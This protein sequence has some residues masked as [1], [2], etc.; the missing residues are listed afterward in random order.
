MKGSLRDILA[1]VVLAV[2]FY[3]LDTQ[4]S[5]L[6]QYTP[7]GYRFDQGFILVS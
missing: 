2:W 6:L 3:F 5:I 7:I 4:G 1:S